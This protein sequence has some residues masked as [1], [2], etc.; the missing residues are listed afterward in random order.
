MTTG[1]G[2]KMLP[3]ERTTHRN[4][5]PLPSEAE[6]L[7]VAPDRT[8]ARPMVTFLRGQGLTVRT[9]EDAD[10]AFEEALLHPPDIVIVDDRVGPTGGIDLCARLKDNVRTHFVPVV[11]CALNDLRSFRVRALAVG[12]DA[13]F[14]PSTDAQER[15][16]RLWSLLRTRAL[17]RRAER[18]Q[19]TQKSEI[20][21]RRHWLSHFLHDLT[22]Q[23]AALA[24]NVDFMSKFAP[25]AGDPRRHDFD[26]SVAD[27]Q[28]V[29]E[30]L[31]GT[32]RTVI[33]YDRFETGQLVPREGRFFLGEAA[34]PVAEELRR[35]AALADKSLSLTRPSQE[36]ALYGDRDLLAAAM[37][38]LGM[39]AL[40]RVPPR[41]TLG[42]EIGETDSGV[43]F[44]AIAPG[45]A[46]LP[47][48]RLRIFEPYGKRAG[49]ATY[50]MGLALAH[51]VIGLHE[52]KIW[53]EEVDGGKG[54]A[55]V[56]ELG[57]QRSGPRP[58]RGE[59]ARNGQPVERP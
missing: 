8:V 58:K 37:L 49:G 20:I 22:G 48:E 52:G 47:S 25:P 45:T 9:A 40:R 43:R 11:V 53:A 19:R 21:E 31:K 13:V 33:D 38:N 7:I 32:M 35:H 10:A 26:E 5:L 42:I 18:N 15:R 41:G 17:Y 36:R 55:F 34:G 27:A 23:V 54:C 30:R 14:S 39:G 4:E 3:D 6:G 57:W 16:A 24:A 2:P 59:G 28:G 51:A 1:L 12:A 56:F 46:L 29:F 44:R 50:G